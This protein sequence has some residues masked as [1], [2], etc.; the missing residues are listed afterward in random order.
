MTFRVSDLGITRL[1]QTTGE[2]STVGYVSYNERMNK[3]PVRKVDAVSSATS[4]QRSVVRE[5]EEKFV[6]AT[7]PAYTVSFTSE[8]MS[9]LKSFKSIRDASKNLEQVKETQVKSSQDERLNSLNAT[10]RSRIE[11]QQDD[12]FKRA[13]IYKR[14]DNKENGQERMTPVKR[15]VTADKTGT[16]VKTQN[17]SY[18]QAQAIK[19]YEN[20]MSFA[21]RKQ[22]KTMFA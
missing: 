13:D 17:Q 9:A 15:N 2:K 12:R 14:T 19:A 21:S 4:K 22:T 20:Q 7:T 5:A 10:D 16:T 1:N 11:T 18:R 6:S 8:S 3:N